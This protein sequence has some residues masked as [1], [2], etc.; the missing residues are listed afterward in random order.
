[1]PL[2]RAPGA[3]ELASAAPPLGQR[4]FPFHVQDRIRPA[5]FVGRRPSDHDEAEVPIETESLFILLVDNGREGRRF[6]HRMLDQGATG[7]A[8]SVVARDEQGFHD[9]AG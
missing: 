5:F 4:L 8:P 2:A 7:A 3:A 6:H 9:I 1:M